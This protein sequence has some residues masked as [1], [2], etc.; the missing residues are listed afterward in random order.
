MNNAQQE[1]K[2]VHIDVVSDVMCPWCFIGKRRLEKALEIVDPSIKVEVDWKPFQ[3]DATL[4]EEGKDRQQYL[5]EK[6]G[7]KASADEKYAQIREAGA[8]ENIPFDFDAIKV[9]PNTLNAHRVIAWAAEAG[10]HRQDRVVERL[11]EAYFVEGKNIGDKA[12]LA[13]A[14]GDAGMDPSSV[15]ARLETEEGL[16]EAR[17]AVDNA[18]QIGVTGVPCF[19]VEQKYGIPGAQDPQTL[20]NAIA[21]I[22]NEKT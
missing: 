15:A 13:A 10:H 8:G 11:F 21:Q 9:S 12:V 3:L 4:P 19:I 6:F 5:S 14:A 7:G 17:Q 22:A 2:V 18:H 20:A 1:Q 16:T